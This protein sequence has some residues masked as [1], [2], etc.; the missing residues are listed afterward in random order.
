MVLFKVFHNFNIYHHTKLYGPTLTGANF[1]S[2]LEDK[3]DFI[4]FTEQYLYGEEL[5]A[6]GGESRTSSREP[7]SDFCVQLYQ[8]THCIL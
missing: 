6:L 7:G 1:S 4:V 8:W 5:V 2:T 3:C